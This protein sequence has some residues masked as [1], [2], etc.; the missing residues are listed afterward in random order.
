MADHAG[1]DRFRQDQGV[2]GP[3]LCIIEY[4]VGMNIAQNSIAELR[5]LVLDRMAADDGYAGL[6]H[7]VDAALHDPFVD[8]VK[9]RACRKRRDVQGDQ[10]LAAHGVDVGQRVGRRDRTEPVA[11]VHDRREE[12]RGQDH[13]N[14]VRDAVHARI[15]G[16]RSAHEHVRVG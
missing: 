6:G 10:R 8:L 16:V 3:R 5:F 12:I 15:V 4:P 1:A 2:A 7:L 14:I 11:I 13:G 9:I